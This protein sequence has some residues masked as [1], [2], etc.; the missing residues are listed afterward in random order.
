MK[1][2]SCEEIREVTQEI[3][4]LKNKLIRLGLIKTFRIMDEASKQIGWEC[5]EIITNKHIT[6]LEDSP[7]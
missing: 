2:I 1:K 4:E 6:K 3:V 7:A 5:E